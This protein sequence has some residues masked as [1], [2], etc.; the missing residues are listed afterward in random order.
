MF[1]NI[2]CCNSA[3]QRKGQPDTD[4]DQMLQTDPI[5]FHSMVYI[6][7]EGPS[8]EPFTEAGL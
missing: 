7:S 8:T 6:E 5:C 2:F 1:K 4:K 3:F